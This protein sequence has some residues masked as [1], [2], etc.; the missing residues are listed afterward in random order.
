MTMPN[1]DN[2]AWH[3]PHQVRFAS[4]VGLSQKKLLVVVQGEWVRSLQRTRLPVPL[5]HRSD[6]AIPQRS[7]R[8]TLC[9]ITATSLGLASSPHSTIV[10]S[11]AT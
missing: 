8:W 10:D 3:D 2:H 11:R 1:A 6:Q 4:T 9:L 5:P 7:R